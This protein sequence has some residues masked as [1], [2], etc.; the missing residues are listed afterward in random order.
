MNRRFGRA[1][2]LHLQAR[3][4]NLEIRKVPPNCSQSVSNLLTL[5]LACVI[6]ST[7]RWR[8][9][10]PPKRRFIINPHGVTSQKTAFFIISAL[11]A[12]NPFQKTSSR[13]CTDITV[14]CKGRMDET[15]LFSVNWVW[16][17][18][19]VQAPKRCLESTQNTRHVHYHIHR[20]RKRCLKR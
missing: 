6:A 1:C 18:E 15:V 11:K 17:W 7:W 3:R 10:V 13:L 16:G 19:R 14:T 12:S 5:F 8:R 2:S 4:N 9:H 20:S